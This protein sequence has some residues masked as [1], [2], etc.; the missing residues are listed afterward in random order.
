LSDVE[1]GILP[2]LSAK[3]EKFFWLSSKTMSACGAGGQN[4]RAAQRL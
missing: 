1:A 3:R 4:V 2:A